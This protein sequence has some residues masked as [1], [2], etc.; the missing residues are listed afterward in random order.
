MRQ[1]K[2]VPQH[3]SQG[4][5]A[6]GANVSNPT[7]SQQKSTRTAGGISFSGIALILLSTHKC[8]FYWHDSH[9]IVTLTRWGGIKSKPSSERKVA[10]LGDGRRPRDFRF[11]LTLLQRSLPQSACA[12]SSLPEGAFDAG[13]F[14]LYISFAISSSAIASFEPRDY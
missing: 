14:S 8:A 9:A 11:E 4:S 2:T 13:K 10:P 1:K 7:H 3:T 5:L 12:D 6:H